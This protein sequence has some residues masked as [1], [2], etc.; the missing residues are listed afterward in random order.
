[1]NRLDDLLQVEQIKF[2]Q[3]FVCSGRA[4][5]DSNEVVWWKNIMETVA[6]ALATVVLRFKPV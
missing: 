4:P 1:M 6:N 5:G 2:N 3:L